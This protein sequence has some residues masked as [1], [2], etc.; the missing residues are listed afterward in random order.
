MTLSTPVDRAWRTRRHHDGCNSWC[1]W[2]KLQHCGNTT[3]AVPKVPIHGD[4]TRRNNL[5]NRIFWRPLFLGDAFCIESNCHGNALHRLGCKS[6]NLFR[7]CF[8]QGNRGIPHSRGGRSR[9]RWWVAL[10]CSS[11]SFL[12][13]GSGGGLCEERGH[14]PRSFASSIWKSTWKQLYFV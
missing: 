6:E 10:V 13:K 7:P 1:H 5:G 4:D 3:A 14:V 8:C 9:R 11:L 12:V 2:D